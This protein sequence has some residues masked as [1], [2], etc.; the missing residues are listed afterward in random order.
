MATR[1]NIKDG[2][3]HNNFGCRR[4]PSSGSDL[5]DESFAKDSG[6][7]PLVEHIDYCFELL[8]WYL[9]RF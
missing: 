7:C 1:I 8:F 5:L 4:S 3:G 9:C 2:S 6:Q